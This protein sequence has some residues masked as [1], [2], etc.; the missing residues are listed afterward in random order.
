MM[1]IMLSLNAALPYEKSYEPDTMIILPQPVDNRFFFV[2]MQ[3]SK[4]LRSQY[5]NKSSDC[6]P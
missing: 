6:K 2:S 4:Q 1:T 5:Q 3:L